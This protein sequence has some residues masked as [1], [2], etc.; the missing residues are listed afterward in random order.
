MCSETTDKVGK[1]QDAAWISF[2]I[3]AIVVFI[4][5]LPFISAGYGDDPD[6]W[7][8]INAAR[9][10]AGTGHYCPS[11]L[12]G[13][14]I[15]E[16]VYTL[17]KSGGPIVVNGLVALLSAIGAA[18]FA[19]TV[20]KLGVG[21]K[22][23]LLAGLAIAFTPVIYINSTCAMDYIWAMTFMLAGLYFATTT[24]P[25]LA[26]VM[27]GLAIGSRIIYGAMLIPCGLML[28]ESSKSH[29]R[30]RNVLIL[31][32][33]ACATGVAAFAPVIGRYGL[34]FLKFCD[35]PYPPIATV[36][37]RATTDVWGEFGR[38]AIV[39]GLIVQVI[40]MRRLN[41]GSY[42]PKKAGV[43]PVIGWGIA[44]IL[45]TLIY[46]RL[47]LESGYLVPAVPFVILLLARFL[48]RRVFAIVCIGIIAASFIGVTHVAGPIF[49]SN[50][51][52]LQDIDYIGKVI[53]TAERLPGQNVIIAGRWQPQ[54]L[55]TLVSRGQ[56][57]RISYTYMMSPKTCSIY[58]SKGYG[59]Y[60]LPSGTPTDCGTELLLH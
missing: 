35:A 59:V 43:L 15:P 25:L 55:G 52:R 29:Q 12:P 9:D 26:G 13:Y 24:K 32:L 60:Y 49:E 58:R 5:R 19:A 14:P 18:F 28:F 39:L 54:I 20:R 6:A 37:S 56:S 57:N 42:I 21:A 50:T 45:Y 16:M 1:K 38:V 2:I 40:L 27:I 46:L 48:E 10:I 23:Y 8:L 4:S 30:V 3:L 33:A 36:V 31:C 41:S 47:P 34:H 53:S 44:A 22:Y 7:R 11:R 17:L 51:K